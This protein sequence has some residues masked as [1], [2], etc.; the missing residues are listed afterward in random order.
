MKNIF[1]IICVIALASMIHYNYTEFRDFLLSDFIVLT[2]V[3]SIIILFSNYLG[4]ILLIT[5]SKNIFLTFL[6]SGI[7][8]LSTILL[9]TFIDYIIK[10]LVGYTTEYIILLPLI[11]SIIIGNVFSYLIVRII[12]INNIINRVRQHFV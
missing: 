4:F 1:I 2:I 9:Y 7:L 8:S 10:K 11:I 3:L 6:I 5:N 12:I